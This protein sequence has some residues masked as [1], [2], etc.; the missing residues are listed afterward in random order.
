[1]LKSD[2]TLY[3]WYKQKRKKEINIYCYKIWQNILL[4]HINANYR[5]THGLRFSQ[6]IYSNVRDFGHAIVRDY[7]WDDLLDQ[8]KLGCPTTY[9]VRWIS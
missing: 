9:L 8:I 7:L 2:K 6:I 5:V 1:M 3:T 4:C